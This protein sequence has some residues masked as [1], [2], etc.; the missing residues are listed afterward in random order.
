MTKRKTATEHLDALRE[1][2]EEIDAMFVEECR[3]EDG[4]VR[5]DVLGHLAHARADVDRAIQHVRIAFAATGK[6]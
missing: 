1:I 2:R 6:R 5:A 3:R 4:A